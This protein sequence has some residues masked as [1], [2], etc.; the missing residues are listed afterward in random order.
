MLSDKFLKVF[1]YKKICKEEN[2]EQILKKNIFEGK[3]VIF[4][5]VFEIKEMIAILKNIY[6]SSLFPNKFSSIYCESYEKIQDVPEKKIV[7]F[8]NKIKSSVTLKQLFGNFLET[9][10][11]EPSKTFVD[12]ICV[13]LIKKKKKMGNLKFVNAHRDTWASN[14]LEQ[15][16]WWF[17]VVK[18]K[19]KNT[20]Y[21]CPEYFQKEVINN[22]NEWTYKK[23]L[24]N[25]KY[26][27]T[28][29]S[30]KIFKDNEK[31]L[32]N[33]NPGDIACFSGHHIHGS[34]TGKGLRISMETRTVS[35][36]DNKKYN[37]PI[38]LDGAIRK[39]KTIWFNNIR[40]GES[41]SK[42]Y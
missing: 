17:P 12:Q 6:N 19:S 8:Q 16:N 31:I 1:E 21:I 36:E 11:F 27:S 14:L 35:N 10:Q 40:N 7:L 37:I 22:A 32:I 29:I 15:I 20:L 33:I 18:L 9:I 41:L 4:K 3:I 26:N 39:K 42:F 23:Y 34:N 38:N 24:N 13:R 5:K 30:R 25:K 28:P 2:F